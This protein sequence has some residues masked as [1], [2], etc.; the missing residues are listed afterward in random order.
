[1][2]GLR[3]LPGRDSM[4]AAPGAGPIAERDFQPAG[5]RCRLEVTAKIRQLL[6]FGRHDRR[7]RGVLLG[8][9]AR[10]ASA[11][12]RKCTVAIAAARFL[13]PENLSIAD[14]ARCELRRAPVLAARAPQD[15]GISAI[16]D[17]CL[18]VALS[19]RAGYLGDRL[20]TQDAAASEFSQPRQC[21]LE[22]VD[23]A[24]CIELIND[25]PQTLI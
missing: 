16:F 7:L 8:D 3:N 9:A 10:T 17:D 14:Q 20:K 18:C 11:A 4:A 22:T 2:A 19:V 15:K 24:Q 23:G 12:Q 6:E 13:A 5:R 1:M 21:I 25:E